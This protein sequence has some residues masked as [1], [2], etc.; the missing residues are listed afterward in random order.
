MTGIFSMEICS[1]YFR[2]SISAQSSRVQKSRSFPDIPPPGAITQSHLQNF[3]PLWRSHQIYLHRCCLRWMNYN[4][5]DAEDALH[6][7]MWK[8]YEKLP[9]YADQIRQV[10]SW[11]T[12]LCYHVC[13]D[14]RRSV[15]PSLNLEDL[16]NEIPMPDRSSPY[17]YAIALETEETVHQAIQALPFLLRQAFILRCI[18]ELSYPEIAQRLEITEVNARKRVE[19][20][21]AKLKK[22][23]KSQLNEEM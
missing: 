11:L 1:G 7:T 22:L 19:Q 5:M 13:L 21:R 17:Q 16:E 9:Q 23:L 4:S 2:A 6:S 15:R 14:L 3:W 20:A 18:E 10:R 8:A 12:K